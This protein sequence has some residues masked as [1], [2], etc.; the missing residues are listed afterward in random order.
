MLPNGEMEEETS[1]LKV[2]NVKLQDGGVYICTASDDQEK[3]NIHKTVQVNVQE[4]STDPN[5]AKRLLISHLFVLI[6]TL[7][8]CCCL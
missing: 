8:L 4:S 2:I 7:L 1:T 3:I 6:V 5:S